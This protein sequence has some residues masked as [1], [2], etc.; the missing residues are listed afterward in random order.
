MTSY[1][2]EDMEETTIAQMVPGQEGYTVP[3]AMWADSERQLWING[4]YDIQKSPFGTAHM[5]IK[6]S[7]NK[8]IIVY[9]NSIVGEKYS[10]GDP[11]FVGGALPIPAELI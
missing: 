5:H 6:M 3:W 11:C 8:T 4:K 10:L 9:K 1:L 7:Q 2:P